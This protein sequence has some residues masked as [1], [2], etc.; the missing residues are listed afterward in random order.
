MGGNYT[1]PESLAG[2]DHEIEWGEIPT[3]VED[4]KAD[5]KKQGLYVFNV[6]NDTFHQNMEH[7][8]KRLNLPD[9]SSGRNYMTKS[10]VNIPF[11]MAYKDQAGQ[12]WTR[13]VK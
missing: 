5:G 4:V 3:D 8:R 2:S 13:K 11:W 1:T 9:G 6:D 10:G 12:V 7:G